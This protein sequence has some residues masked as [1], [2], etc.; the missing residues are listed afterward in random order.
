MDNRWIQG[1][2][3]DYS[4]M[5]LAKKILPTTEFPIRSYQFA[6]ESLN[7]PNMESIREKMIP[8]FFYITKEEEQAIFN[9]TWDVKKDYE[10]EIMKYGFYF[11]DVPL[12]SLE[13]EF[14]SWFVN[15]AIDDMLK[16][17]YTEDNGMICFSKKLLVKTVFCILHEY[18]HYMDYK[19]FKTKK[20]LALWIYN[21]KEPYR[22]I[23]EYA[24]K[25]NMEGNLTDEIIQERYRIYRQ[26]EDEYSADC[27][28]LSNLENTVDRAL[29]IIWNEGE[30]S[31]E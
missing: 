14:K 29:D 24:K 19:K 16:S 10:H 20:E 26:C 15:K 31:N 9:D 7:L 27:Y 8:Q 23:D 13:R 17:Y 11:P 12:G 25:M 4:F 3:E 21:V 5:I 28:A 22:K 2:I 18:G 1:K 6:R 30:I